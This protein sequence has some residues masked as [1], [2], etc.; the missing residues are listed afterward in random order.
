MNSISRFLA[1]AAASFTAALSFAQTT[2]DHTKV[3][4]FV[5]EKRITINAAVTDP[6][7]VKLARTYFKAGAQADY[8]FVPMQAAGPNRYVATLPAPSA[9]TPSIEYIVLAQ[10][11]DG[12]VSRTAAYKVDARKSS[13]TPA[14]QSSSKAGDVKVF[15]EAA[16][17]PTNVAGFTDSVTLDIVESSARLGAA[18]GVYGGASASAGGGG[19]A[20]GTTAG[21]TAGGLST[22]AIIGGVAIAGVAAAAA[23]SGG[24]G[25]G[26]SSS[27]GGTTGGNF[28]GSWSGTVAQ[29]INNTCSVP[30]AG[31]ST[32][33]CSVSQPFTGT[34]DAS[35]NFNYTVQTATMSCNINGTPLTQPVQGS[36][37]SLAVPSSGVV[38]IPSS[39]ASSG[40]LT[41]TCP[42]GSITFTSSPRRIS[43]SY[44][45]STSGS[46]TPGST[47]SGTNTITWSGQ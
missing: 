9:S 38:T 15:T 29:T 32:V 47:C 11:N 39:S 10:N 16:T 26:G 7:G 6:K 17:A 24:G 22:A 27:P 25:G 23:G 13:E 8:T 42:A 36:S 5:P 34:V 40:G 14:W 19:A 20:A 12:T 3:A 37:A 46:V 30:G 41:T 43:G 35:G 45:C 1:C 21:A 2:I 28:S 44:G 33:N 31:N 18:A 4:Y